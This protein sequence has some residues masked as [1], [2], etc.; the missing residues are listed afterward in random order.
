MKLAYID[1][2]QAESRAVGAYIYT[3]FGETT[4]LDCC[5]SA[6]LHSLVC[7]MIWPDLGWPEEF[8]IAHVLA[9]DKI[10]K[11]TFK[12]AKGIAGQNF[13]RAMS[14]RDMAKRA[15]H[16]FNYRGQPQGMSKQLHVDV[17]LIKAFQKA[18]FYAF[19]ELPRWHRWVAEQLQ[20][21]KQLTTLLGRRR[22][23]FGRPNDDTTLRSAIA[24]LPQSFATGDYMN[25]GI[26]K[27]WKKNL[28]IHLALQ[29]HDAVSFAY[30]EQDEEWII[31]YICNI[32]ETEFPI[33]DPDGNERKFKIPT[34]PLVGWNL[35]YANTN[36]PDGLIVFK[37]K[38]ER[39][40]TTFPATSILNFKLS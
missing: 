29:V 11:E 27:L 23:F 17:K 14:Y 32:L 12:I 37:G 15:G 10:S 13:Y 9:G 22:L 18:Y 25:I 31:P 7:S 16:A 36:N 8:S 38:D 26:Y 20:T 34:E 4:Y 28:P 30:D 40:R 39:E 1:L 5:E 24:F 3:L 21:T 6:D 19:P 2:E 33:F 35:S